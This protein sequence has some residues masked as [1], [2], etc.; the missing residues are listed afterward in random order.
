MRKFRRWSSDG[1]IQSI[2]SIPN[3][4][5]NY[6]IR[7]QKYTRTGRDVRCVA[8]E[9]T[10]ITLMLW[11]CI[12][13]TSEW[14]R[15]S[16]VAWF[17]RGYKFKSLQFSRYPRHDKLT[18][19]ANDPFARGHRKRN[20]IDF[21]LRPRGRGILRGSY[22]PRADTKSNLYQRLRRAVFNGI[23]VFRRN[24]HHDQR[25][26]RF[27]S[28]ERNTKTV[29]IAPSLLRKPIIS[30]HVEYVCTV[31]GKMAATLLPR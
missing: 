22:R 29:T 12:E 1:Q 10:S 3:R 9:S 6:P 13:R 14:M 27:L 17:T 11:A 19:A 2:S 31:N 21:Q 5:L 23:D 18:S 24:F 8:S 16:C 30:A 26:S 25:G 7:A 15:A 28:G 20:Q 4:P